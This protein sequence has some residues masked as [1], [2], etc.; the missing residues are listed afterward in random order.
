MACGLG[1]T[2]F[3]SSNLNVSHVVLH[4][5]L[6]FAITFCFSL[7]PLGGGAGAV[8]GVFCT[9]PS[10]PYWQADSLGGFG[11]PFRVSWVVSFH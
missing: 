11:S 6:S 3:A 4:L 5:F 2:Y 10:G 8:S 1:G 9:F 7:P